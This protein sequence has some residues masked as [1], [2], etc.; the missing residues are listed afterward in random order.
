MHILLK[1]ILKEAVVKEDGENPLK[2]QLYVDMDGVLVDLDGGFKKI[3]TMTPKEYSKKNGKN[4]F[5]DVVEKNPNFWLDLP[6]L[7]DAKSLWDVIKDNFKNPPPIILSEGSG[8]NLAKQKKDW[9]KK[10]IDSNVEV[11]IAN[12]GY[13][14]SN[15]AT[16][17]PNVMNLLLDDTGPRD[18]EGDELDNITAW[19]NV[20]GNI[21]IHH[22]D[23]ASSI[24]KIG[25]ILSIWAT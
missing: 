18:V 7:P 15:Y 2:I 5:W 14:K 24:Q 16:K 1:N 8:S 10:Y 19:E 22:T 4:A 11:R 21:A 12:L 20:S 6:P 25:D 3:T 13:L 17:I 23:A 9:I